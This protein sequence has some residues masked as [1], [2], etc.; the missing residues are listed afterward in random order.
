VVDVPPPA[1]PLPPWPRRWSD[2][3]VLELFASPLIRGGTE[4]LAEEE[5]DAEFDA[6]NLGLGMRM[7]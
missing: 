1:P 4:D 5:D 7:G 6:T 3:E 2:E